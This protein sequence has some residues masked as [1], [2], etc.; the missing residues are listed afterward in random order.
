MR[1]ESKNGETQVKQVIVEPGNATR[2]VGLGFLIPEGFENA[3]QWQVIFPY[4]GTSY[5]FHE[6]SYIAF[7][8]MYEKMGHNHLGREVSWS[9]LGEQM[10]IVAK[11]IG[12]KAE[13]V[14]DATGHLNDHFALIYHEREMRRREK[15][16]E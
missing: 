11:I 3:G 5:H 12:G 4:W 15:R 10:K 13:E 2:Y 14:T 6:G 8:Y 7:D 16:A 9:D 1:N